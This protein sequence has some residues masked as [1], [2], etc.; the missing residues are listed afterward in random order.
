ML[1]AWGVVEKGLPMRFWAMLAD[2]SRIDVN[3]L[4]IAAAA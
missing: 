2:I 4:A 3:A 1:A